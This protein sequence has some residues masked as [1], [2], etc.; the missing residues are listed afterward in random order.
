[1]RSLNLCYGDSWSRVNF[2]LIDT[3]TR[4]LSLV[5]VV[6]P[7]DYSILCVRSGHNT[8]LPCGCG[9]ATTLPPLWVKSGHDTTPLVG[10]VCP[11]D[12]YLWPWDHS[13]LWVGCR[14]GESTRPITYVTHGVFH[15]WQQTVHNQQSHRRWPRVVVE[16]LV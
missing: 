11:Q 1:M 16:I 7:W 13:C 8:T 15:W 5:G 2:D 4:L 9:L 14:S 3:I 6:W 10:V 12:Y